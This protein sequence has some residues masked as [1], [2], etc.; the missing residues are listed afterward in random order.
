MVSVLFGYTQKHNSD[1]VKKLVKDFKGHLVL[2][3]H[4]VYDF[5]FEKGDVIECGCCAHGRRYF[6]DISENFPEQSRTV[7]ETLRGVYARDAEA[8]ERSLDARARLKL[9]QEHSGPLMKGLRKWMQA[10]LDEHRA[11]PNSPLGEA[12]RY[13]L[14][15]WEGLTLFLRVAGAP[16]DNNI[17]ERAL[18]KAILHR[19]THSSTA[20]CTAPTSATCT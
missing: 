5:L 14:K 16:L 19:K 15:H 8:R 7:L 10:E 11:E 3:A 1:A 13:M 12:Y 18:K 20:R 4:A 9:H 2:D 17:C 6:V